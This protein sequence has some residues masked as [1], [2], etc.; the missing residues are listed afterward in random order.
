MKKLILLIVVISNITLTHSQTFDDGI[1][2]YSVY[3]E[4]EVTVMGGVS[5]CPTGALTIPTTVDDSGTTYTVTAINDSSFLDCAGLTS[6]IFPSSL[7]SIGDKAFESCIGL[8]GILTLPDSLTS[9][10]QH[11]FSYCSGLT[12]I[13]F[14]DSLTTIDQLAFG[15]CTGL[16]GTLTFPASLG[17]PVPGIWGSSAIFMNCTGLTSIN[18]PDSVTDIYT[19]TFAHCTGLIGTLT[20]PNSL[21]TISDG[22]FY[23]CTG[24]T[25]IELPASL[26]AIK[27]EAFYY[28]TGLTS[29]KAMMITPPNIATNIFADFIWSNVFTGV[30]T[31]T[32]VLMVPNGSIS[33]YSS[34]IGWQDFNNITLSSQDITLAKGLTLY[35]NPAQNIL[36]LKVAFATDLK[37]ITIYNMF[38]QQVL[39]GT[40]TQID[41][42]SLSEGLFVLKL[43]TSTGIAFK[44]FIKE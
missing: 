40:S 8:T 42:S 24:L 29:I 11:A 3:N 12:N 2:T 7:I 9:I 17:P 44:K 28:C 15:Y 37:E 10:G 41:I 36:F 16:T 31:D 13:D 38:G 4:S 5:G 26:T 43:E 1:L 33:A 23:N 18:F 25:S 32:C 27:E 30:D 35:P 19:G 39:S 21:T 34:A 14:P 20:F 6:I 22:A